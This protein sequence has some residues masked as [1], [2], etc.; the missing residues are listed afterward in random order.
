[1][2][3]L[4]SVAAYA[5]EAQW[6]LETLKARLAEASSRVASSKEGATD[7][8][9]Q[10]DALLLSLAQRDAAITELEGACSLAQVRP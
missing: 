3:A 7:L 6:E 2:W 10:R 9:Q 4:L 1:L 8:E 5:Q